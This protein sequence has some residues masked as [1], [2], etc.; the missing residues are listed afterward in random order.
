MFVFWLC[1]GSDRVIPER[2]V[3]MKRFL[4][5]PNVPVAAAEKYKMSFC[6]VWRV[7]LHAHPRTY[8]SFTVRMASTLPL[9]KLLLPRTEMSPRALLQ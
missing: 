1:H 5:V 2:S 6:F 8:T 7:L 4:L 9:E 3:S